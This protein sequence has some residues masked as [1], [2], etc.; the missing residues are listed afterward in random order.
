MDEQ[1]DLDQASA[2]Y[3]EWERRDFEEAVEGIRKGYE[4]VMA[5]RTKPA[6]EAFAELRRKHGLESTD[7]ARRRRGDR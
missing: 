7:V 6:D 4:S 3:S 1:Q 2:D 5:G